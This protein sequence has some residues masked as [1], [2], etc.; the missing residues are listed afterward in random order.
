MRNIIILLGVLVIGA[1]GF[2]I[3]QDKAEIPVAE[4][5]TSVTKVGFV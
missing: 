1:V 5:E 4:K 3:Y 2:L